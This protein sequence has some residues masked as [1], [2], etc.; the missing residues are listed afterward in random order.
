MPSS[1]SSRRSARA[2]GLAC[3]LAACIALTAAPVMANSS[4]PPVAALPHVALGIAHAG[5]LRIVALGSSSTEGVGASSPAASYPSRLQAYL[6]AAL[7]CQVE[8]VNAGLGGQDADQ[9]I[10]RIP[11]VIALKPDLVVWQTGSNDPLRAVP[12][13]RFVAETRAGVRALRQAGI[14]VML[15]EPQDCAVLRATPG[16]L[17]Y[18]DALRD[19]AGE[20]HV[21][22]V[23]RFD[24]MRTW[25]A[26]GRL[27][28]AEMLYGDGLHMTDGG[29]QQL[30]IA[31]GEQIL[32]LTNRPAK[33]LAG[34]AE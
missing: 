1:R 10:A 11:A 19:L 17:A 31:V 24:L 15:M 3:S 13:E 9:M 23:R 12:L 20:M 16:S 2:I 33:T 14:D 7:P 8:V 4:L 6:R 21:P 27:T 32:E 28:K 22:L 29:Y 26:A 30:A 5:K 25:L 34:T 18:R